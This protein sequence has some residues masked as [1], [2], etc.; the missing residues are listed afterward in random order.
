M[1]FWARKP[2]YRDWEQDVIESYPP[3]YPVK[4]AYDHERLKHAQEARIRSMGCDEA[5]QP[6]PAGMAIGTLG[7]PT[8][9]P[10]YSS[11]ELT[12]D[13]IEAAMAYQPWHRGQQQQGEAVREALVMAA[14]AILRNVPRSPRRTLALQ[15]LISARM[16]ANCA[17]SFAGRF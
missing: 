16:D 10:Y 8:D 2:P 14:K 17:I 13:N 6:S 9:A 5:T 12:L 15:H 4:T 11:E 1:T 3:V 7:T